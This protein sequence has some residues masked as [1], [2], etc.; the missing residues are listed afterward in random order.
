VIKMP[1]N[2][3][4]KTVS[5]SALISELQNLQAFQNQTNQLLTAQNQQLHQIIIALQNQN[6]ILGKMLSTLHKG[7]GPS[8]QVKS[9]QVPAQAAA[10][11][12]GMVSGQSHPGTGVSGLDQGNWQEGSPTNINPEGFSPLPV[13]TGPPLPRR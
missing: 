10:M 3:Q 4:P 8:N 2:D 7:G 9:Q 11:Y 13:R 6:Q 12:P 1:E 5:G